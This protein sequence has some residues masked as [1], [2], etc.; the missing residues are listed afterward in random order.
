MPKIYVAVPI[1]Y[2]AVLKLYVAVPKIYVVALKIYVAAVNGNDGVLLRC[3]N[4]NNELSCRRVWMHQVSV[5][6]T[7]TFLTIS[8]SDRQYCI[9]NEQYKLCLDTPAPIPLSAD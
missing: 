1:L 5:R 7:I 2:V 6:G 9:R 4:V 3:S 8:I